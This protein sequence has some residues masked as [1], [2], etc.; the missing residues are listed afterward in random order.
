[1]SRR[2]GQPKRR[3][4]ST[5]YGCA[6]GADAAGPARRMPVTERSGP[7]AGQPRRGTAIGPGCG[8]LGGSGLAGRAGRRQVLS[9]TRPRMISQLAAEQGWP[10]RPRLPKPDPWCEASTRGRGRVWRD[11][12]RRQRD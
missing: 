6:G 11:G 4:W 3:A 10:R 7:C 1:M 8:L 12:G 2:R 5:A 9:G